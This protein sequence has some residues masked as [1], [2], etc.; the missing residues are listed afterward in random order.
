MSTRTRVSRAKIYST[1][2]TNNEHVLYYYA[3][4]QARKNNCNGRVYRIVDCW[5]G[6]WQTLSDD[7]I[8][9]T[10]RVEGM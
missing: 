9:Y 1:V 2:Q 7:G 6:Y 5:G 10:F 3:L 4:I 8:V